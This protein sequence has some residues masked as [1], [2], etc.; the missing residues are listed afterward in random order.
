M[1]MLELKPGETVLFPAPY[2]EDQVVPLIVTT[3]RV[4]QFT[5]DKRQELDAKKITFLGRQSNR[6]L[7]FLALFFVL[8]GLPVVG[9]GAYLYLSVHGMPS[10]SDQPPAEENPEFEDP[11]MVRIKGAVIAVLGAIWVAVGLLCGKRQRHVVICRAGKQIMKL[12]VKDKIAQTQVLMTLQATMAS[13]KLMAA[14]PPNPQPQ[15]PPPEPK[16]TKIA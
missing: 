11:G 13:A 3:L 5:K 14:Q 7:I 9:Y 12:V 4:L 1:G 10:F 15:G 8:T 16:K 2:E 6:P